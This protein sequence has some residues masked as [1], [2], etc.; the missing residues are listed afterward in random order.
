MA[1]RDAD[2]AAGPRPGHRIGDRY[3]LVEQ[4]S[5]GAMG[6]VHRARDDDGNEVA[7]KRLLDPGQAARF[8]I[9][10]RLLTRL[11][12]PRVVRVFEHIQDADGQYL[13]MDLVEGSDLGE[14]LRERGDP[15]LPVDQAL[16]YALQACEALQYVHEQGIVHRDVKPQNFVLGEN[17]LVLVD[18]G[19]A[20]EVAA[21]GTGTRAMGTPRYM[22]PEILVGESVSPRSD[23]YGLA[24]TLWALITG[25]PPI[26]HD[27]LPLAERF[28]KV[29]P[30]LERT[31]RRTLELQPERRIGS[32]D[33]F[34]AALGSPLGAS[35]GASLTISLPRPEAQRALLEAV[36]RTAAA[37]FD[38]AAASIALRDE[39]TGELIYQSAWGAGADEIVGVRLLPGEGIAG[40]VLASGEGADIPDCRS[41]E[42]FHA[43]IAAGTG[44]VPLTMLVVP[45]V[46]DGRAVG[47]L[48]LLD[49]RDGE[50]YGPADLP[51]AELFA[52]LAA[53]A[54]PALA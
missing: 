14:V 52:E 21:G 17:G 39:A 10:A 53:A 19:I 50:P 18:F 6:A 47:A 42:R 20:R 30:E 1:E 43:Q 38:A 5:A 31:L 54:L 8:E 36:V 46:H 4:I 11:Q 41:D 2:P 23:I 35:E 13:V 27:P 34:A 49:R 51:R 15:G 33:A 29:T 37:V 45:L 48:S 25:D 3:T 16:E 22:A 32:A 26:Y 9:E 12:H 24:A 28:D 7:I 40:A 44:Y